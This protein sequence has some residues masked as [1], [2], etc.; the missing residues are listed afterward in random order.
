MTFIF[1]L[2]TIKR[3]LEPA[4]HLPKMGQSFLISCIMKFCFRHNEMRGNVA[5][6]GNSPVNRSLTIMIDKSFKIGPM[7]PVPAYL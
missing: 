2:S 7:F 3:T 4:I 5:G 1:A 6:A